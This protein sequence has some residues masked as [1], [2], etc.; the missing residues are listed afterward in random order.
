MHDILT[1]LFSNPW[2][3][4]AVFLAI[5]YLL[6]AII[7]H[8][9]CWFAAF[10]STLI[11]TILYWGSGL[12]MESLLNGFYLCM[13]IYGWLSW[14]GI[15]TAIELPVSSWSKQQHLIA[16]VIILGCTLILGFLL[17]SASDVPY[18]DSFTTVGAIVA[19]YMVTRK[20]L[21]NWIYWI[22]I[23]SFAIYLNIYKDFNLTA[24]LLVCYQ[25]MS[26]IGYQRWL[27]SYLLS[28]SKT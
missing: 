15:F 10:F 19:T 22:V 13:A 12:F 26:I 6:L 25:I 11:Y 5:L 23:N 16:I 18:L 20:I 28:E 14:K 21:Q 1:T 8:I 27:K 4:L 24:V 3:T 2:E 9:G 7:Q 17:T